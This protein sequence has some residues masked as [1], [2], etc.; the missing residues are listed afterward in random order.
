MARHFESRTRTLKEI[1]RIAACTARLERILSRRP[2]EPVSMAV[3]HKGIAVGTV[4]NHSDERGSVFYST[5]ARQNARPDIER[6]M[7]RRLFGI[8]VGHSRGT[9]KRRAALASIR[10]MNQLHKIMETLR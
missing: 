5:T 9:E 3:V 7:A 6:V 2:N 1:I 10:H 4:V 8:M